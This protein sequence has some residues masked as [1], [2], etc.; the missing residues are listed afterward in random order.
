MAKKISLS[1]FKARGRLILDTPPERYR[2]FQGPAAK[3]KPGD[4]VGLD[5]GFTG[6]DGLP[7]T[8]AYGF[9][10]SG[11]QTYEAELYDTDFELVAD[12]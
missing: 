8:L 2:L 10:D 6:E 1:A 5:Q 4:I 11:E 12:E 3:P 9:N 7:M